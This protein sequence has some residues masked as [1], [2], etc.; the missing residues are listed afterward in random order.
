MS[1]SPG[2]PISGLA[3]RKLPNVEN[4][5]ALPQNAVFEDAVED[6]DIEDVVKVNERDDE[7]LLEELQLVVPKVGLE[8]AQVEFFSFFSRDDFVNLCVTKR[9]GGGSGLWI[10]VGGALCNRCFM[11]LRTILCIWGL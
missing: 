9:E 5:L 6:V 4:V 1:G 8:F 10:F 7:L 3:G 2:P 11:M